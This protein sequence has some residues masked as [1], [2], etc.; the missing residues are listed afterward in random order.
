MCRLIRYFKL[1][2]HFRDQKAEDDS[3]ELIISNIIKN[4]MPPPPPPPLKRKLRNAVNSASILFPTMLAGS[5]AKSKKDEKKTDSSGPSNGKKS[6]DENVDPT[7]P[8][9]M[10]PLDQIKKEKMDEYCS[11]IFGFMTK[12][13]KV[14]LGTGLYSG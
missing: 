1:Y 14:E 10:I 11:D 3:D 9:K 4:D 6:G 8:L 13:R 7:V 12:R 5:S 2:Y